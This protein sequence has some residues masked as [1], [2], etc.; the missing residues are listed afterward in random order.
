MPSL[1]I[2]LAQMNP[3]VGDIPGNTQKVIEWSRRALEECNADAIILQR[4]NIEAAFKFA[5]LILHLALFSDSEKF[6]RIKDKQFRVTFINPFQRFY[7]SVVEEKIIPTIQRVLTGAPQ[8]TPAPQKNQ[9]GP[10]QQKTP[11]KEKKG[12]DSITNLLLGDTP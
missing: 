11:P 5:I 9:Q 8:Q 3:L 10:Q 7:L 1:T 12:L 6:L 2:A 4:T